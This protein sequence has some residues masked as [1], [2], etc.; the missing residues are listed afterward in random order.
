MKTFLL[1]TLGI[2]VPALLAGT[3][4]GT[5]ALDQAHRQLARISQWMHP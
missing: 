2:H 1:A 5:A 4:A 3:L